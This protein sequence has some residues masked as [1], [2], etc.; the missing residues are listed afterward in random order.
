MR[1]AVRSVR[2]TGASRV[3]ELLAQLGY[4]LDPPTVA[5]ELSRQPGTQ[6]VVAEVEDAEIVGVLALHLRR[7]LQLAATSA[8]ID[9]LVV[10]RQHRSHGIGEAL[11]EAALA[12][13]REAGARSID[14][15]SSTVR[16][17][18]RR[19]YERV[20]FEIVSYHFKRTL[21]T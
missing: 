5:G 2:A 4:E 14:L 1:I 16:V 10:D 8:S 6:V 19:F 12:I 17:E 13:S 11:V 7:H 18:A 20:G 3:S 21:D 9:A 15:N